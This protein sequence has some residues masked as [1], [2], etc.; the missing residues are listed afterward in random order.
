MFHV[1]SCAVFAG[2]LIGEFYDSGFAE[3][4]EF[5]VCFLRFSRMVARFFRNSFSGIG[6][7]SIWK[8]WFTRF[9]HRIQ[10]LQPMQSEM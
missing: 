4:D 6:L 7:F 8:D 9:V 3:V 10:L 2:I 5:L 1:V